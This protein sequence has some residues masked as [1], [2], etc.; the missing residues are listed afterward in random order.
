MM[1]MRTKGVESPP[2]KP[3]ATGGGGALE[4]EVRPGGMLVQ[5]R[6]PSDAALAPPP[7]SPVRVRVKHNSSTLEVVISPQASFGNGSK[8]DSIFSRFPNAIFYNVE[9]FV[10]GS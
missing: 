2:T 7:P 4:W 3:P 10:Q 1:R 9:W 5:K 6:N 8:K